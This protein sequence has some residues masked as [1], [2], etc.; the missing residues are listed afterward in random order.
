MG[1]FIMKEIWK[2][3]NEY[4]G[5][6]QVSNFG[7]IK[8]LKFNK[9]RLLKFGVNGSGYFVC[10]LSFNGKVKTKQV[11]QLVAITFLNH[12]PNGHKWVVDHID[13]NKINNRSDNLRSVSARD[14]TNLKHIKSS[15]KYTGVSWYKN[16][17]KW[18]SAILINKK[19]KHLGY[20]ENELDASIRYQKELNL[21][22]KNK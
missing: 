17:R 14:N 12:K 21:I 22:N 18:R 1:I 20:Y 2:D 4:D 16:L 7:N 19:I 9:E 15:S 6:Y 8:S 10:C 3:I 11:H 5:I 13:F